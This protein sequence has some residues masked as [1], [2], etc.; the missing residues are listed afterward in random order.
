MGFEA[1]YKLS[2]ILSMV[3]RLSSPMRHRKRSPRSYGENKWHEPEF[4][5]HDY[6]WGGYGGRRYPDS[7]G[8]AP[9]GGSNL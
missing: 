9:A 2:V 1:I 5:E 3:D 4:R 6:W 7:C 8:S